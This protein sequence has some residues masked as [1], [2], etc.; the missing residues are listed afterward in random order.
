[1]PLASTPPAQPQTAA[2]LRKFRLVP[3]PIP[4]SELHVAVALALATLVKPPAMW[5]S[6]SPGQLKLTGEQSA[7][8]ARNGVKSAWPD[9]IVINDGRIYGIA[10]KRIGG[11]LTKTRTVRAHNGSLRIIPGQTDE[12][13][14]LEQAGMTIATCCSVAGVLA[15]LRSW[16]VPLRWNAYDD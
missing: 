8:L 7:K 1:M 9:I 2:L 14:K 12:F 10:L 13:P 11:K 3:A 5:T 16:G 6:L 4:E 15:T